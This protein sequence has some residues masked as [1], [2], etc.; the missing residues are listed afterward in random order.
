MKKV[1]LRNLWVLLCALF[2]ILLAGCQT[3]AE[4]TASGERLSVPVVEAG[5][6]VGAGN[7]VFTEKGTSLLSKIYWKFKKPNAAISE[8]TIQIEGTRTYSASNDSIRLGSADGVINT[9]LGIRQYD[10]EWTGRLLYDGAELPLWYHFWVAGER[11]GEKQYELAHDYC[12]GSKATLKDKL[13]LFEYYIPKDASILAMESD[14]NG[15]YRTVPLLVARFKTGSGAEY[16]VYATRS[17]KY[18]VDNRGALSDGELATFAP[19]ITAKEIILDTEQLFQITDTEKTELFAECTKS[20]YTLYG[21]ADEGRAADVKGC[22]GT[23]IGYLWVLDEHE[24]A[25][26]VLTSKD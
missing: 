23:F 22:V 12:G 21:A 20:S 1:R 14:V 5:E 16:C 25:D 19:K 26:R 15:S 24:R 2:A 7:I 11:R 9:L 13:K 4:F 18:A 10:Y 17:K 3:V 8:A 6:A